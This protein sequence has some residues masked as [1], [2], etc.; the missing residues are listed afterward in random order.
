[1]SEIA[2]PNNWIPRPDQLPLWRYLSNGGKRALMIA[3]RRWGKDDVALHRTAMAAFERVGNYWHMLPEASQARKAIWDAVNPRTGIRRID[4]AFPKELRETTRENEMS[5]RFI[6]GSM[7]QVVGSDNYNSLVG[8]P[9]IGVVGSEWALAN[10]AA[11]AYLRPILVENGGWALFVTTPR[12]E[13]HVKDMLNAWQQDPQAF[14]Q[15]L[16]IADSRILTEEQIRLEK[17]AYIRELGDESGESLFNQEWYCSFTTAVVGAIYG[18]VLREA[19]AN[20][21]IGTVRFMPGS[22]VHSCWD[23]GLDDAMAFWLFQRVGTE[24]RWLHYYEAREKPLEH[25]AEIIRALKDEH[26][27][28]LGECILPHD[29]RQRKLGVTENT[30]VKDMFRALRIGD[31]Q[32]VPRTMDVMN[33]IAQVQKN[34]SAFFIDENNCAKG[35]KALLHYRREYDP[36][37]RRFYEKPVHDWASHGC[38]AMRAG[39]LRQAMFTSQQDSSGWENSSVFK[40]PEVRYVV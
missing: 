3:H 13:N 23:I 34:F 5:I 40:Q 14:T 26:G 35:V 22:A 12:G 33:D 29:A 30:T 27:F 7:W 4:E 39:V 20:K 31:V 19:T 21:R 2:L 25:F 8:S 24:W 28:S 36:D 16:T 17:L 32:V 15:I 38:D 9:P 6:N 37:R 18:R 11:W 1:M 10:P